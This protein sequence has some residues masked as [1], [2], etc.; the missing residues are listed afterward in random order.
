MPESACGPRVPFCQELHNKKYRVKG[1]T[2]D[3]FC[4]RVASAVQDDEP[5]FRIILSALRRM[6][7][8]PAG[9]QQLAVGNASNVTAFNCF[10]S[11][12]IPDDY[13]GIMHACTEAGQTMRMGGGIGMDFSTLRPEGDIIRSLDS[14]ASG[15]VSFMKIWD[16]TCATIQSK[17]LRR[18]AM[19]GVLRVDHPDIQS[20]IRAKRDNHSL[21]NFNISVAITDE[22]MDALAEDGSYWL[23]FQGSNYRRVQARII[24]EE[25]M[26]NTWDWS[27]PGVLFIDRINQRNPLRYCE[28]IAAVNP[29]AEQALPPYGACLLGSMNCTAY[30][31][32]DRGNFAFDFKQFRE[33]VAAV[34]R[35]TDNIIDRTNYPLPQQEA[36]AKAKRR[37]GI[38]VTGLANAIELLGFP[39]ASD[40]YINYQNAILRVLRDTAYRTSAQLAEEKGTFPSFNKEQWLASE[41]AHTL[42]EDTRKKIATHGL[43]NG[44]LLSIAPTGTISMCADNISPGIEP[45]FAAV[46]DRDVNTSEG[47]VTTQLR[48]WAYEYHQFK[49][50]THDEI[51]VKDHVRVLCA[52]QHYIDACISK[53]C[54]VGSDVSFDEFKKVYLM[55]YEQ[56]AKGCTTYRPDG[57]RAAIMRKAEESKMDLDG[58][59]CFID[60]LTGQ[61]ECA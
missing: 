49:C 31:G 40:G 16:A 58:S 25:I 39:Y 2:F 35:A 27:E 5:H 22:F 54:N 9:R 43:R 7:W 29:C 37:M 21:T 30:L 11:S 26:R 61:K 1:E 32:E 38:G 13:M 51:S 50:T 6:A 17:G 53:T 46:V 20:F 42:D 48:D 28:T 36:E 33:D 8:L 41:Y 56:G 14:K 55:A 44:L 12:T 59:A 24:W 57:K 23:R 19:M 52:A 18:G 34:V 4:V 45:V 47:P 15:P 60:P 10:V 3:D